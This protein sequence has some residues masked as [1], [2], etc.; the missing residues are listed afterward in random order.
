VQAKSGAAKSKRLISRPQA[1]ARIFLFEYAQ[2]PAQ[3]NDL[4]AEIAAGTEK[5]GEKNEETSQNEIKAWDL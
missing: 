4:K 5:G 1:R 2:L 3:G